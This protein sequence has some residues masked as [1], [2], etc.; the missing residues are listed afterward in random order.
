M[1]GSHRAQQTQIVHRTIDN[2]TMQGK[3]DK[4]VR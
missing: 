1:V 2:G 4:A 3:G